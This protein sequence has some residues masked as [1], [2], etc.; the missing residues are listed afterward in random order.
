MKAKNLH[1]ALVE[2]VE[3]LESIAALSYW[4]AKHSAETA[5]QRVKARLRGAKGWIG[6]KRRD[7]M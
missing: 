1:A 3:A 4:P 2:A 6:G 7:M 5:L